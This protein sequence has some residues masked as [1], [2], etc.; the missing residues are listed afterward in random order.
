MKAHL[1]SCFICV[2]TVMC[3]DKGKDDII[4]DYFN[5]ANDYHFVSNNVNN[6]H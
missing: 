3:I 2:C 4:K 5:H 6:D 1:K